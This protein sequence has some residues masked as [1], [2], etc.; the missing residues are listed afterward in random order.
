V[1]AE[2]LYGEDTNLNGLLDSNEKDGDLTPPP[3]NGDDHLDPG[4]I[5]SLTCY[6]YEN[7]GDAAGNRRV[8]I[9]Q[10]NQQQLQDQLGIKASQ[11]KWVVD[12]R[13]QGFKSI[14]DLINDSSPKT[15]SSGSSGNQDQAE[16]ID[17][18]TFRRIADRITISDQAKIPGKININTADRL[19]LAALFV[20]DDQSEQIALCII[21]DRASLLYGFT[22][23][24]DLL[25][26]QSVNMQR[27]KAV[28]DMITVRSDVFM[29]QCLATADVS[30]ATFRTECIV[31]RSASP[32][33]ILYW[34]QGANY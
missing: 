10:A 2:Y 9:T 24:A 21:A 5:A 18:E 34:Y 30:G 29:V 19:T 33:T 14:A 27:F 6:A 1:T 12:N 16:P 7:N 32:A 25:N 13:G 23:V 4:W 8:N 17:L 3:D 31:D 15:S 20:G 28:A 26:Q 22:S 11:A